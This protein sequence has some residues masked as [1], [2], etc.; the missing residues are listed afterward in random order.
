MRFFPGILAGVVAL[1]LGVCP[2][3][4][5]TAQ[6][7]VVRADS[8]RTTAPGDTARSPRTRA[9]VPGGERGGSPRQAPDPLARLNA[10]I[11]AALAA[12]IT[13][14]R[15]DWPALLAT[16]DRTAEL[17][18]A[19]AAGRA[20]GFALLGAAPLSPL[21]PLWPS[22]WRGAAEPGAGVPAASAGQVG[23]LER[24]TGGATPADSGDDLTLSL[25]T[26][27]ESKAERAR[28]ETCS[29]NQSFN[30]GGSC[31]SLFQPTFGV[32]F[33]VRSAGTVADR[34]HVDVDYD[35][36][37]EFD[38]SNTISIRYQGMAGDALERVE[39][40]NVSFTPPPSSFITAGI[41]IGNYGVQAVGHMGPW[42]IQTIAAQQ[43]GNV[44][45]ERRFT[46]GARSSQAVE[47]EIDDYEIEP[48]RFFFTV[49]PQEFGALYPNVDILDA[50]QMAAARSALAP[51]R[52]PVRVSV[53]RLVL[54]GRPANP[55]G[56]RFRINGDP[57]SRRGPAYELLRENV[58]YYMD[59]SRLWLALVRP[60]GLNDERLVV[61]YTVRVNGEETVVPTVGGT[62]DVQYQERD[63]VANLVWQ[64]RLE[65]DAPAFRREIRSVYRVGG[66]DV[67]RRSVSVAIAT[68]AGGDQEKPIDGRGDTYL[69]RFGLAQRTNSSAFDVENRLWPRPADPN[70]VVGGGEAVPII[71]DHFLVFPSLEPF[72][73]RGLAGTS[74][75]PANDTLYRIPAEYLYSAQ[76]PA[77]AYRIRV[78]YLTEAGDP[79]T[80][81]LGAV[82]LRRASER[83][84]MDGQ[85]LRRGIDYE[86][87]YDLGRLRFL[88]PE[89]LLSR[90]HDVRVRFEESPIF[91][92]VPTSIFGLTSQLQLDAGT[93]NVT[94]I[95]QRQKT[96][97]NR[98]PLGF[99][100]ASSIVAGLNGSF[101]WDAPALTSFL[102]RLP[103]VHA[104]VPSR[105]SVSGEFAT[106]R[107]QLSGNSQAYLESFEGEGGLSPQL[108]DSRWYYGSTPS[109]SPAL[110]P[111]GGAGFFTL[112]RAASL[113]WQNNGRNAAGDLITFSIEQIDPQVVSVGG[114]A[115]LPE[116]MLWL[117]LQPLSVG[118]FFRDGKLEQPQWRIPDAPP[119][120]RWRSLNTP[121]GTT[122]ADL[123]RVEAI[124]FWTLV[125]TDAGRRGEN[126]TLI[127]DFGDVS[128]NSLAFAPDTLRITTGYDGEPDSTF[129]GKRAEGLDSLDSELDPFS[130]TFNQSR[131]DHGLSG[132]VATRLTIIDRNRAYDST[133]VAL[134]ARGTS[135]VFRL[136]DPRADCTR[137]NNRADTED[138][139]GD[140]VLNLDRTTLQSERIRR[141]LVDLGDPSR[142][143]RIGRCGVVIDQS[144]LSTQQRQRCWVQVR[145]PFRAPDDALNGGPPLRRVQAMR[146]TVVSGP[147]VPDNS[148][149]QIPVA[150]LRLVGAPWLKRSER[151]LRGIAGEQVGQ[152]TVIATVI[153]TADRDSLAGLVYESPPG[154]IDQPEQ[155][156]TGIEARTQVNERS[157]RLLATDLA[158]YD[159]AEAYVRFPEGEKSLLGY[160]ELRLWARGRNRGWG[161]NGALQFFVKIGRDAD[162]FYMYRTPVNAGPTRSAWEPELVVDLRRFSRLRGTLQQLFLANPTGAVACTGADSLLVANTPAPPGATGP[163]YAVC[164]DGYIV[165][166][167]NPSVSPPN[168]AA[169]QELAVGMV[170][171]PDSGTSADQ[172]FAGDT[173]EVW[174]N[175]LRLSRVENEPGYAGQL[176]VAVKASDIADLAVSVTRRDPYF[177][178]LAESPSFH[179]D[180]ALE[181]AATV[182]LERFLPGRLGLAL[183]VTVRHVM[184]NVDPLY[185]S[186]A[187]YEAAGIPGL[188]TPSARATTVSATVRRAAGA[189][190]VPMSALLDHLSLTTTFTDAQTSSEYQTGQ[191]RDLSA[192]VEYALQAQP[193]AMPL[194][195]WLDGALDGLPGWIERSAGVR[196]MRGAALQYTPVQLRLS[197]GL[198][199]SSDRRLTFVRPDVSSLDP[200]RLVR[201]D[202]YLWRSGASIGFRPF[203]P[204]QTNLELTS[205]RDLRQY[206][207]SSAASIAASRASADL[208]GTDIGFERE[209]AMTGTLSFAPVVASWIEPRVD[210]VARFDLL[211][212]PNRDP[213]LRV[214][215]GDTTAALVRRAAA[216]GLDALDSILAADP[217]AVDPFTGEAYADRL[218]LPRRLGSERTTTATLRLDLARALQEHEMAAPVSSALTGILRPLELR[219]TRGLRSA[220]D[221]LPF[222]PGL[223][224]Q[225]GFGGVTDFRLLAGLPAS[226]AG[227]GTQL[228]ATQTFVFPA[229]MQLVA[230]YSRSHARNWTRDVV[231]ALSGADQRQD[232]GTQ[233]AFPDLTLRWNW[234]PTGPSRLI[235]DASANARLVHT[236]QRNVTLADAAV[237]LQEAR[238]TLVQ[239]YPVSGS[240]T[241]AFGRLTTSGGYTL[242]MRRDTI[243]GTLISSISRDA[244]GEI[245]RPFSL[246][247]SW[248]LQSDLRTRAAYQFSR[249]RSVASALGFDE[250]DS[251]LLDNGRW[252]VTLDADT[253][254]A[255]NLTFGL[256]G[257][258]IVTYDRNLGRRLQQTVLTAALTLHF[259]AGPL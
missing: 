162:N 111:L 7:P 132:D 152:G 259:F 219:Y 53:Y 168:M 164:D 147:D 40:G 21:A 75:N 172:L 176:A 65:P 83:V 252:S 56:P 225:F 66:P 181:A 32:Q 158:P 128:E 153:G 228:T 195:G 204:L 223:G 169:V 190:A 241:W 80:L 200:G 248:G 62:P 192:T 12:P 24:L 4:L 57:T 251:R 163:R 191:A 222:G 226:S 203:G 210:V 233:T 178:Q 71:R 88:H 134:C 119:G 46:V 121:L 221:G 96:I 85:L 39:V 58:D 79:G 180:D 93:L 131:D 146:L 151:G 68:G 149:V 177:R 244:S 72:A 188:R 156:Q 49:D 173:L 157:L 256:Q 238:S 47:R 207:D 175:D 105:V 43:R 243:P 138:L 234:H 186:D 5:L 27:L 217:R 6:Q 9:A 170:R 197:T 122:G 100:A 48:R 34:F 30:L 116:Q 10:T 89:T 120:R 55:N 23:L 64:P 135:Q 212:D 183:P 193:R 101:G 136:G 196:S 229:G 174:V 41:P 109:S 127:L 38:A 28:D 14:W 31:R 220:F 94:A 11:S 22:T 189:P 150:R 125:D 42:A 15:R 115:F 92:S 37:R 230:R 108:L 84:T 201:G 16:R 95:G 73:H 145:V 20:G 77:A 239:S 139:D 69:Q 110:A 87:D 67:V 117:T 182:H 25:D 199:R 91:G 13:A 242:T 255:E 102:N 124:E 123:T 167:T 52:R 18:A 45:Q 208:L 218:A 240:V 253:E 54:S 179:T 26:R 237:E 70:V 78:R 211:R 246:P 35:S 74:G 17:L 60:L 1:A 81:A 51:E 257:A 249:S 99:E 161:P 247:A 159:R 59:P 2:G 160:R 144:S 185:V 254:V 250:R 86:V 36:Q 154:V 130:R 143:A 126:P 141:Y 232:E 224:Y 118:G 258:R 155:R 187:D 50:S 209:R 231:D 29:S 215:E 133:N 61:A 113:A 184:R 90:P 137:S 19:G 140:G 103:G 114:G 214:F 129:R 97:F 227:V 202:S 148:R 3:R 213:V 206:G 236:R 171:L 104:D 76:H 165:Y 142:W 216:L 44:V 82:Q 112:A 205:L 166:T 106:S 245:S 194:G 8:G 235:A 198:V 107:P 98:P 33:S 63:Q